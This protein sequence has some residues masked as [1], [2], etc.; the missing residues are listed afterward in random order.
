MCGGALKCALGYKC[1]AVLHNMLWAFK[2][3]VT[4]HTNEQSDE[5][6]CKRAIVHVKIVLWSYKYAMGVKM[7][8][9]SS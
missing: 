9:G 1:A 3:A 5:L 4:S 7:C 2:C 6:V 8:S